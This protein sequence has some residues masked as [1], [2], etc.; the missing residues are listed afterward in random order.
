LV[1]NFIGPKFAMLVGILREFLPTATDR[2]LHLHG[3]SVVGQ[4]LL[5]RFHRPIGRLLVG[6]TEYVSYTAEELADHIARFC[7]TG[8]RG[9]M[10]EGSAS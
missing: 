2:E 3:F 8:L 10:A 9:S 5:Y 7:S 1:R 4:C 6:E